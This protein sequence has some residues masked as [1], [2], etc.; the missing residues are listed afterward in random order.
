MQADVPQQLV[1]LLVAAGPRGRRGRRGGGRRDVGPHQF[2]AV[3]AFLGLRGKWKMVNEYLYVRTSAGRHEMAEPG[4]GT[5]LL[6]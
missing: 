1:Q 3:P 4:Q 2:G 6:L 5:I